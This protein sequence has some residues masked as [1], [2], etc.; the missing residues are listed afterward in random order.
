MDKKPELYPFFFIIDDG[1]FDYATGDQ[2]SGKIGMDAYENIVRLATDFGIKIP[3]CFTAKFMDKENISGVGRPLEYA[4]ELVDFLKRNSDAIEIGYHGLTHEYQNHV[5]EFF[6]LDSGVRVPETI[7]KD[8]INKSKDIFDYWQLK[9]PEI[10]VPPYHAWERGVTDRLAAD[11]GVRYLVSCRKIRYNGN[12]YQWEKSSYIEF[13]PRTGLGLYGNDY[14][15]DCAKTRRIKLYPK[16]NIVEFAKDYIIPQK[17]Y[18]RLRLSRLIANAPVHSYMAHIGNFSGRSI[19]FWYELLN[20][21][22][23]NDQLA[24]CRDNNHAIKMF[25]DM[26][27]NEGSI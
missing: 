10:F 13:L 14:D 18:S 25:Y 1:G 2:G 6:C 5:G 12:K 9:F 26:E 8:H 7:Q 21:V 15:I 19:K 3:V 23:K 27:K 24:I 17:L 20:F 22:K 4:S 16:K 11:F